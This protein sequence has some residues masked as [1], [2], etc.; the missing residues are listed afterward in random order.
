MY[1]ERL[2]MQIKWIIS[3]SSFSLFKWMLCCDYQAPFIIGFKTRKTE[4]ECLKVNRLLE[5]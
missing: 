5:T 4:I 2:K 3:S 1:G